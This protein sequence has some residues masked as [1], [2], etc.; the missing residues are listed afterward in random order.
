MSEPCVKITVKH[1]SGNQ[2]LTW[3]WVT[4]DPEEWASMSADDKEEWVTDCAYEFTRTAYEYQ[5]ASDT[6]E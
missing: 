3:F 4:V 1:K 6:K 5:P 2:G